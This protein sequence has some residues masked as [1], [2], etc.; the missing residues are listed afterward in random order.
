MLQEETLSQKFVR[1][2]FW[3]YFFT[4]ISAPLGY[5]VKMTLSRG[6]TV[7]EVGMIYGVISFVTLIGAYNDLGFTE[8]LNFFLPRY[9]VNKEFWKAKY[10]LRLTVFLQWL[11]SVGIATLLFFLAP[12]LAHNYFHTE[13]IVEILRISGLYFIGINMV[14]I[15]STIFSVAQDVKLQKL[16][17]FIRIGFTAI[18]TLWLF[19][20]DWW[21]LLLYMWAWIGGIFSGMLFSFTFAY[22]KYYKP[23]FSWTSSQLDKSE[24][25]AFLHYSWATLLTANIGTVLSQIDMQLIIYILGATATGYYSNYLSLMN[26]PFIIIAP[27]IGFLFP[28]ISELHGRVDKKKMIL[29]RDRFSLYFSIIAVW[30][31]VFLFQ[32]WKQLAVVFFGK[33]FELSGYIL[34]FSAPFLIFNILNQ[35]NFQILAGTGRVWVR[36]KILAAA[37][38]IN[39]ILNLIF[40]HYF[41]VSGA[42]LAVGLSWIPLWYMGHRATREH[43]GHFPLTS[44]WKNIALAGI[45]YA[46][47]SFLGSSLHVENII[48]TLGIAV[49]I[50]LIIFSAGNIGMLREM[51]ETIKK[52]RS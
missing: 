50:N 35:I 40:I 28:V 22:R 39:L 14:H 38:P 48:I 49:L 47:L 37:I 44:L 32:F 7:D 42:A 51:L 11:S 15:S 5:I 52:N 27:I 21:T 3:L 46:L 34:M 4:F 1:K 25:R 24:R 41:Y 12:W 10:L 26:I 23:Y 29:V 18:G 31:S 9:I 19:L 36:A 13:E 33:S 45:T 8:S 17:D 20:F 30:A 43:H 16:T 6:L 2:G